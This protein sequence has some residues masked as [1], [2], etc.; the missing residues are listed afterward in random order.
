[1]PCRFLAR[2]KYRAPAALM[3]MTMP[4]T[5]A[6]N[7][8]EFLTATTGK[9]DNAAYRIVIARPETAATRT[10]HGAL[11]PRAT[12]GIA[13]IKIYVSVQQMMPPLSY[14]WYAFWPPTPRLARMVS[15]KAVKPMNT[16]DP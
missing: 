5:F 12:R 6:V 4:P 9:T 11:S 13:N 7:D 2:Q 16:I 1:M 3:A 15:R 14:V 10:P 8:E